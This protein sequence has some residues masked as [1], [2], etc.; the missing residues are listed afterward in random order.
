MRTGT[1][2][3][4]CFHYVHTPMARRK[5]NPRRLC[6]THWP[7]LARALRGRAWTPIAKAHVKGDCSVARARPRADLLASDISQATS[8]LWSWFLS[9]VTHHPSQ[10]VSEYAPPALLVRKGLAAKARQIAVFG[11][12][13]WEDANGETGHS[14][15][16]DTPYCLHLTLGS[17]V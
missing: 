2:R 3:S 13:T 6:N 9:N 5:A 16:T 1:E 7:A 4:G 17:T 8:C 10:S 14:Y 11:N 15:D 12:R